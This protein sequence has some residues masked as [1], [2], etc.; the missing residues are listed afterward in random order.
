MEKSR[1]GQKKLK[2]ETKIRCKIR[3][4]TYIHT[5]F[6]FYLF[7]FELEFVFRLYGIRE[8][9]WIII[10]IPNYLEL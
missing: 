3:W 4:D 5:N 2:I 6:Y 8:S 10:R 1:L 9:I 7:L